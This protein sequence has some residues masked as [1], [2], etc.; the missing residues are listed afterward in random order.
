M[1]TIQP[2]PSFHWPVTP[3]PQPN[4]YV[5]IGV[6]LLHTHIGEWV[7]PEDVFQACNRIDDL[8]SDLVDLL[9]P[10]QHDLR[11]QLDDC[12]ARSMSG[13][14]GDRFTIYSKSGRPLWQWTCEASGWSYE[15]FL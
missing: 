6:H 11:T 10:W 7:D 5:E 14:F 12:N 15:M 8:D 1:T 3:K 13:G 4:L 9:E 2:I